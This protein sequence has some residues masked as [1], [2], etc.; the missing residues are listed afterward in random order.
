MQY[1]FKVKDLN[2][3]EAFQ[4]NLPKDTEY[5]LGLSSN[6]RGEITAIEMD[7][8]LTLEELKKF[9]A[10]V[11]DGNIMSDSLEKRRGNRVASYPLKEI[12]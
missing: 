8:E 5:R 2:H 10:K 11:K 1:K 3:F 6:R 12:D 4:R 9:M 7:T